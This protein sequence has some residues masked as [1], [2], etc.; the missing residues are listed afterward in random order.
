LL[1]EQERAGNVDKRMIAPVIITILAVLHCAA[2]AI[3]FFV[4]DIE[5]VLMGIIVLAVVLVTIAISVY[6]LAER[7]K[8]IRSGEEDDLGNY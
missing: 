6:V 8:E 1:R 4:L 7:I 2:I 3:L 5:N